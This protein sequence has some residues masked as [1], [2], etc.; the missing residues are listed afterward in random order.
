[1]GLLRDLLRD[2]QLEAFGIN[3]DER[4]YFF[5]CGSLLLYC[6]VA[7]DIVGEIFQDRLKGFL[8][9]DQDILDYLF[10]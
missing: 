8:D 4:Q 6:K 9:L 5:E 2:L 1:M 10:F 3:I 7:I